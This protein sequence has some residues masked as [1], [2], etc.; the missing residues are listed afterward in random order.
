[1][2]PGKRII[3]T[4][5]AA[6]LT[7]ALLITVMCPA[8]PATAAPLREQDMVPPEPLVSGARA[9]SSSVIE[10]LLPEMEYDIDNVTDTGK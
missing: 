2:S 1:M 10:I 7:S 6:V 8:G 5:V 9:L 4:L 3:T